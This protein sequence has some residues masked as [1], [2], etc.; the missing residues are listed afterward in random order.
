[1]VVSRSQIVRVF[2]ELRSNS[3]AS[4]RDDLI[5]QTAAQLGQDLDTVK[6]VI[7]EDLF[8]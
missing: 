7:S 3:P 2:Q 6:S 4:L 8:T 5:A 1:M